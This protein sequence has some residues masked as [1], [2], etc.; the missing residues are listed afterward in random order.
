MIGV[1]RDPSKFAFVLLF[2]SLT[3]VLYATAGLAVW[4][5]FQLLRHALGAAGLFH[6]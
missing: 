3:G 5:A 2:A 1:R 4:H 6:E